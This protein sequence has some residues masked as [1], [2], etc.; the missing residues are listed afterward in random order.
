MLPGKTFTH[1]LWPILEW[2]DQDIKNRQ[3][4]HKEPGQDYFLKRKTLKEYKTCHVE[5]SG[6]LFCVVQITL[7]WIHKR[8]LQCRLWLNGELRKHLAIRA[9]LPACL[10]PSCQLSSW[11][12]P[13]PNL[14]LINSL[15]V[16]LSLVWT[17]LIDCH[18][19]KDQVH[20]LALE[21][22]GKTMS[23]TV[24]RGAPC[25][26]GLSSYDHFGRFSINKVL[27]PVPLSRCLLA[28]ST[29]V[30]HHHLVLSPSKTEF[31]RVL[32]NLLSQHL[33]FWRGTFLF[34]GEFPATGKTLLKCCF[35]HQFSVVRPLLFFSCLHFN[36][37]QLQ[38][39]ETQK[40]LWTHWGQRQT[41]TLYTCYF[42]TISASKQCLEHRKC[43]VST[44]SWV[45]EGI[46][47]C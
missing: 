10:C 40:S 19:L 42:L 12:H 7:N 37:T 23:H 27:P 22:F 29:L 21:L 20:T 26:Q 28:M 3:M 1:K 5:Q 39:R 9:G 31:I 8:K 32:P 18:S 33:Y 4:V 11:V 2:T 25:Q 46:K 44:W 43:S 45:T 41:L 47:Q 16:K 38:L 13:A 35:L 24:R 15:F 17:P 14:P 34:S 30:F 36:N 6:D